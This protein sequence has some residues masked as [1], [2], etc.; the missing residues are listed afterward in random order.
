[1]QTGDAVRLPERRLISGAISGNRVVQ[2]AKPEMSV[3]LGSLLSDAAR[4]VVGFSLSIEGVDAA[5]LLDKPY[6]I[7]GYDLVLRAV[8]NIGELQGRRRWPGWAPY[9][10]L[11]SRDRFRSLILA[12]VDTYLRQCAELGFQ[13]ICSA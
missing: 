3:K 4:G 10:I 5:L 6:T 8:A 2:V 12:S 1:V 7:N 13:V 9:Q 11:Q